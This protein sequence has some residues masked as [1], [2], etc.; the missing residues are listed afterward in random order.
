MTKLIQI[1]I[2]SAMLA[3]SLA[4]AEKPAA[5][6][7][8]QRS[9]ECAAQAQRA[10]AEV[11]GE[12]WQSHYSPKY[13]R[14][15]VQVFLERGVPIQLR[16]ILLDAFEMRT[17]ATEF[18]QAPGLELADRVRKQERSCVVADGPVNK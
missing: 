6:D 12:V 1:L 13:E 8:W 18:L 16:W 10:A 2:L 3:M 14:C 11:G 4:A 9:K 7:N 15:Y 17:L 5:K